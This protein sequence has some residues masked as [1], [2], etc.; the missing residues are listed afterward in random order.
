MPE[1][2]GT[3]HFAPSCSAAAQPQLDRA[4]A[5]L[6]SFE[7]V[8]A[9]DGFEAVLAT[10]P[11]C[12]IAAWGIA[13]SRWGNPFATGIKPAPQLTQGREAVARARRIGI[14]TERERAYV[15]AV[16]Q[17]YDDFEQRDQRVRVVAYRDAMKSLAARY[18]EDREA[19]V[20]YA[21][22]LASAAEPTDKTYASLLEAGAILERLSAE[23]PDHPG[24]AHYIIHSYDVPPLAP[25]A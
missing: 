12:A 15:D 17:L 25:R 20:F 5:L 16:S 8:H 13:L 2:L 7:F 10:D 19:P 6:H 18:P 22:A 23:Q 4:V 11:A 24:L 21:L 14:R 3:V 1:R 9:I